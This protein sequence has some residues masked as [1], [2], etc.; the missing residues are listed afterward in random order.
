MHQADSPLCNMYKVGSPLCAWHA[1]VYIWTGFK[2]YNIMNS[3]LI[4][5]AHYGVGGGQEKQKPVL[6]S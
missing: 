5:A 1:V 3:A 2:K 4:Q 6:L